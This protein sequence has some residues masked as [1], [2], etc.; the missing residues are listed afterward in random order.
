[1]DNDKRTSEEYTKGKVYKPQNEET[2]VIGGNNPALRIIKPK[3]EHDLYVPDYLCQK[4]DNVI[5]WINDGE[6]L[7]F[8]RTRGCIISGFPGTGKT[9]LAIW[10]ANKTNSDFIVGSL[11]HPEAVKQ[12]FKIARKNGKPTIIFFDE[13]DQIGKKE[14][15]IDPGKYAILTE[16]L[17]QIDGVEDNSNIFVIGATNFRV[18]IDQRVKRNER[19]GYEIEVLP[20]DYKTRKA[21]LKIL[22]LSEGSAKKHRFQFPEEIIEAIAKQ[23]FG[24]TGSDLRSLM[25]L[26]VTRAKKSR[27]GITGKLKSWTVTTEDVEYGFK[28]TRPTAKKDMPFY[29]P[30]IKLDYLKGYRALKEF[31][32]Q[33]ID[34]HR[35]GRNILIYGPKGMG[36][37]KFPEA[38]AG[39]HGWNYLRVSGSE[40]QNKFVGEGTKNLKTILD[41]AKIMAPTVIIF[42]EI[43]GFVEHSRVYSHRSDETAYF[44]SALSE[45]IEKVYVIA[46]TNNPLLINDTTL[47]RFQTKV[48]I[49]FPS[50]GVAKE[51]LE[52]Y[53]NK[54]INAVIPPDKFFSCRDLEKIG[55]IVRTRDLD[56]K[57]I[58]NLLAKYAPENNDDINWGEIS[59]IAGDNLELEGLI[60]N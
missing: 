2:M 19:L 24:Y 17:A 56:E 55:E 45:P 33:E 21:I 14:D 20:P 50:G 12:V 47:S 22:A 37:T 46:T 36:K 6:E 57:Q 30:R 31:L 53:A 27:E 59:R 52:N 5:A 26:I 3:L 13:L 16:L 18:N 7:G 1:M 41:I 15:L 60:R 23:T 39:E 48:C 38:L 29:E 8:L 10:L 34:R 32:S 49:P 9:K 4:L 44:N 51:I 40:L 58:I 28:E 35:E 54:K 43:G 42:D 11:T 25:S